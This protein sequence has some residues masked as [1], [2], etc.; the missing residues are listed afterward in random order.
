MSLPSRFRSDLWRR[1][2]AAQDA[3][4]SDLVDSQLRDL[5][6]AVAA[7]LALSRG[8]RFRLRVPLMA[9]GLGALV[10]T[11][12]L[13]GALTRNVSR[14]Q[15]AGSAPLALSPAAALAERSFVADARSD[16]PL[17]FSDGSSVTFRAGSAGHIQRFTGAGADIVLER[18]RLEAQVVHAETTLWLLHAGPYRVRVTGTRFA[19]T[20]AAAALEVDLYE[21]AVVIDGAVLGAALPLRA[22]QRLKIVSGTVLV[23]ALA[24]PTSV[25]GAATVPAPV[26]EHPRVS[27]PL[28]GGP[29]PSVAVP[30]TPPR[31]EESSLRSVGWSSADQWLRLAERGEYR[32]ALSAAKRLGWSDLC[33]RL[34]ARRLLTLGDVAR[35]S[36]AHTKARQAFQALVTRFPGDRLAADAVFSLGRLAFESRHPDEAARWFGRYVSDW[37]SAPL[38]DQA[39]GRLLECAIRVDDRE[40][41]R[42]AARRYLARAPS[43]PHATLAREVLEQPPDGSP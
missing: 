20:W 19:M 30:S 34:D 18:G 14:R 6:Q 9:I 12:F 33:R 38:A 1:L 31:A 4:A 36:G 32:D 35:Y 8:A 10:A 40:A 37:P 21:G 26:T 16:L 24:S 43:G 3:S 23:E 25:A 2:A 28:L 41:A 22:G 5:G 11:V 13:A 29:S 15:T 27:G 42:N 17:R 7:R 39:A